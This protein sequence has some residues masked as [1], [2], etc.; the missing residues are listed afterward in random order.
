MRVVSLTLP[1]LCHVRKRLAFFIWIARSLHLNR[2]A[3]NKL[4]HVI[5]S[6]SVVDKTDVMLCIVHHLLLRHP[7]HHCSIWLS[8]KLMRWHILCCGSHSLEILH[9]VSCG[10]SCHILSKIWWFHWEHLRHWRIFCIVLV[11]KVC[12]CCWPKLSDM[13]C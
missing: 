11:H 7:H 4:T 12:S 10:M 9:T 2:L 6:S 1:N 13:I 8:V 3:P 5:R